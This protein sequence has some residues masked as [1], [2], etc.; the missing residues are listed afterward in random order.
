MNTAL[1]SMGP[2]DVPVLVLP[3]SQGDKDGTRLRGPREDS[4]TG[5]RT[6]PASEGHERTQ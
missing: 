5:T 3:P 2:R 6:G 4:V 1:P